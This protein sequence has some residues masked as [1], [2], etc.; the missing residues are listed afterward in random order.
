MPSDIEAKPL[1]FDCLGETADARTLF[2]HHSGTAELEQSIRGREAGGA[3]ADDRHD[4]VVLA[5]LRSKHPARGS[6]RNA[7]G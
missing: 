1:V 4:S 3:S 5:R 7:A 6:K 2:E